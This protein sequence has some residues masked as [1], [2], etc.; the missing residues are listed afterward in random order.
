M[1]VTGSSINS[2]CALGLSLTCSFWGTINSACVW[3]IVANILVLGVL[4]ILPVCWY[5]SSGGPV[6]SAC[7]WEIV[8]NVLVM[9]DLS[10][11]PVRWG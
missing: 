1:L 11:I 5:G 8:A 7:A 2:T 6:N 3:E 4:S 9:G 10:T